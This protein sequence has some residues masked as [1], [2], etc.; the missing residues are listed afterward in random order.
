MK[1]IS[2]NK[3]IWFDYEITDTLEVWIVLRGCEVKS[4]RSWKI[5]IK[6]AAALI[7]DWELWIHNIDIPLYDKTNPH[8]VP[9]YEAKG[10]RKWLIKKNEL[11]KLSSNM[12]K[13]W[14]R[15]LVLEMYFTSK[16]LVKVKLWLGKRKKKVEKRSAI[17]E[18]ETKR[19][20]DKAMR[21]Y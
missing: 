13:S 6:D 8:N 18:R 5:N 14:A 7:H 16:Q 9:G 19:Q 2:K 11:G 20:M 17:K 12:D 4:L 3:R 1:L 15:L 21:Q 10:K